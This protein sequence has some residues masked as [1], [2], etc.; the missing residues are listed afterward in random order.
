[1]AA[2]N[3]VFEQIGDERNPRRPA[4]RSTPWKRCALLALLTVTGALVPAPGTAGALPTAPKDPKKEYAE[5]KKR[6]ER[7]SK[8]YRGELIA[9]EEAKKAAERATDEAERLDAE[10]AS[11]QEAVGRLAS[12]SYMRGGLQTMA[13]FAADP[14]AVIRQAAVLEHLNTDNGRRVQQLQALTARADRARKDAEA[15]VSEVREQIKDLEG[16]RER[17]T[18][19]LAKYKPQKPSTGRPDGALK[20]K[21]PIIGNTMT[22]RM[23]S[24]LLAIDNKF[25]PFPAIGCFR[26]N[27]PQDHGSGHACDFMESTGG[28][29]PSA[30]AQAH[31]DAVAQYAISNASRLG[32]KYVIWKQRIWDV[33]SGGGWRTMA[34]RGSITQNHYDHVHISV[35]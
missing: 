15:K 33:R 25:G 16:Q 22:A 32:I 31:G 9:L 24:V 13:L 12:A 5:L 1:V 4:R 28:K 34:D 8:E 17:V 27:D 3:A 18:K 20:S 10:L 23:R 7:L 2:F 29:M 14:A 6:A 35:L 11:A 26:N 19:L 21:S 30:S